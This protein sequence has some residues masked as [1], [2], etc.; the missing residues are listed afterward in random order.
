[1]FHMLTVGFFILIITYSSEIISAVADVAQRLS[2]DV[3]GISDYNIPELFVE[4]MIFLLQ[5]L[6]AANTMDPVSAALASLFSFLGFLMFCA[7][8]TLVI[9]LYVR[10]FSGR[11]IWIITA[12]FGA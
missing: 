7:S 8:M 9:T 6:R 3:T 4:K 5:A 10:I 11:N 2:Q 12:G 1:M